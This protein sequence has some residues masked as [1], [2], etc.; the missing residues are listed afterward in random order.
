MAGWEKQCQTERTFSQ[1][2]LFWGSYPINK[3]D[4][5]EFFPSKAKSYKF[6]LKTTWLDGLISTLGGISISVTRKTWVI[7]E[8]TN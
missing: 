6:A 7:S 4:E 1:W 2:Y 5:K 3:M 8:C